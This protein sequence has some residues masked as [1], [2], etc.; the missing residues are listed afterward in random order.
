MLS[1]LMKNSLCSYEWLLQRKLI[2]FDEATLMQQIFLADL[3]TA[4]QGS[5]AVLQPFSLG[6]SHTFGYWLI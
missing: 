3:D 6:Q 2:W 5:Q 1:V 4:S